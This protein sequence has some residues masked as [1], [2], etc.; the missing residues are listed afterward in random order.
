M[1]RINQAV[2]R[3]LWRDNTNCLGREPVVPR[4]RTTRVL[5]VA[6]GLFIALAVAV[7]TLSWLVGTPKTQFVSCW[8]T[9]FRDPAIPPNPA[10]DCDRQALRKGN[11]FVRSDVASMPIQSKFLMTQQLDA[12]AEN[13]RSE[14]VVLYVATYAVVDGDG[15]IVLLTSDYN[16]GQPASGLLLRR[17]LRSLEKS[18][19]RRKLLVLDISWPNLLPAVTG[20]AGDVSAVLPKE[21]RTVPDPDRL[22][23]CACSPGQAALTSETMGRSVFGYYFEQALR[24]DADQ[25]NSRLLENGR[26]TVREAAQLVVARVDRWAMHNRACRQT[27]MLLGD[28]EDFD[29]SVCDVRP[30]VAP[31]PTKVPKYPES[32]LAG[33]KLREQWMADGTSRLAPRIFRQLEAHLLRLERKWRFE[34][35]DEELK[36]AWD[37]VCADLKRELALYAS[38]ASGPAPVSLAAA[39]AGHD[40][41]PKVADA[42]SALMEGLKAIQPSAKPADRQAAVQKVLAQ[43]DKQTKEAAGIDVAMAVFDAAVAQPQVESG[44]LNVL[45]GVLNQRRLCDEWIETRFLN[46]LAQH[47]STSPASVW[48]STQASRLLRIVQQSEQAYCHSDAMPWT[49][50]QLEAAAQGRHDAE[51]RFWYPEYVPADAIEQ[52]IND[53][54]RLTENAA[55]H[56]SIFV[57]AWTTY[58]ESMGTLPWYSLYVNRCPAG[59]AAWSSAVDATAKL[60]EL[61]EAQAQATPGKQATDA[62]ALEAIRRATSDTRTA[63][64]AALAP[65]HSDSVTR[66]VRQCDDQDTR[67]NVFREIDAVLATPLL[68]AEDRASLWRARAQLSGRFQDELAQLDYEDARNRQRTPVL[69]GYDPVA[70]MRDEAAIAALRSRV[71]LDLLRLGGAKFDP[72]LYADLENEASQL[73]CEQASAIAALWQVGLRNEIEASTK[74]GREDR[75]SRVYPP[76]HPMGLLDNVETNPTLRL[77]TFQRRDLWAWQASRYRYE[78]RDGVDPEFYAKLA[79]QYAPYVKKTE[80]SLQIDGPTTLTDLAAGA[81]PVRFSIPWTM[82]GTTDDKKRVTVN[83]LNP[84]EPWLSVQSTKHADTQELQSPAVFDVSL[85]RDATLTPVP[86]QGFVV[87][88]ST[89]GR[90]YHQLIEVPALADQS[91]LTIL[92]SSD[93]KKPEPVIER[94]QLRSGPKP[95]AFHLFVKNEGNKPKTVLVELS[96]GA[97]TAAPV[98]I[99]AGQVVPVEFAP[100]AN[101]G[102]DSKTPPTKAAKKE[103]PELDGPL[104]V[105]VLDAAS[106]KEL[107]TA[108]FPVEIVEPRQFISVANVRFTPKDDSH[109]RLQI[110]LRETGKMPGLPCQVELVIDADQVPGLVSTG[111]GVFKGKLPA[112][113]DP[114]VLFTRNLRLADG[115]SEQGS[116]SLTID[117]IPRTIVFDTTFARSGNPTTPVEAIRPAMRLTAPAT[118]RSG[119]PFA[120]HVETDYSPAS[121]VL[122]LGLGRKTLGGRLEMD[123]M[124][125]LS[126]G[127]QRRVGFSSAGKAGALLFNASITDWN[128]PLDTSGIVGHRVLCARLLAA[129]GRELAI[130]EQE[131]VLGDR[132]PQGVTF[133]NLPKIASNKMPLE[134]S[135]SALQSI[136]EVSSVTFFVGKPE[137]GAIPKAAVTAQGTSDAV[138]QLW[139]GQIE[140][141]PT[142]KGTIPVSAQFTNAAGLSTFITTTVDVTDADIGG[143]KIQGKVVEGTIPQPG[144]EVILADGKGAQKGKATTAPDGSFSFQSLKPGKYVA[145]A[146]KPTSGRKGEASVEVTGKSTVDTTIELWL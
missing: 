52:A 80:P 94:I 110:E 68:A 19:S 66:L 102:S 119:G 67:P 4:P 140:L 145:K 107:A 32:L 132:P 77:I 137:N 125:K 117:G 144:V 50:E 38:H 28:G 120:A 16:P 14:N 57:N 43:F 108:V 89:S 76:L 29:L 70:A 123:G 22:V 15:N 55:A 133:E 25:Y 127:R 73:T 86:P 84:A 23:L 3:P 143:G 134:L 126:G 10:A 115:A 116:F 24:G 40:V 103:L 63:L 6:A 97:V 90:T 88:W 142:V 42:T 109:N 5:L 34:R 96:T 101:N 49:A 13:S 9:K 31:T 64:Q 48:D 21:L 146:S 65:F 58:A 37:N 30:L 60:A 8:V 17:V 74:I 62:R 82:D 104:H 36:T 69:S 130:A 46:Q 35:S 41:D 51:F 100:A 111:D 83:V 135:A 85:R 53:A 112:N 128:V 27:P 121:A 106:Q 2:I 124:V 129:D 39:T 7:G 44:C 118:G 92:L 75:L 81:P 138:G 99:P 136:P 72:G 20:G 45:A 59:M 87:V 139:S 105:S 98:E 93:P 1:D 131:V 114:L 71:L 141:K 33:W 113:G 122:E 78:T 79:V 26:V 91:R 18:P 95:T 56:Q 61:L 47:A 54:E 11:Y 12:L